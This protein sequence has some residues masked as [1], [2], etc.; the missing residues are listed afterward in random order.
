MLARLKDEEVNYHA[1][2][3]DSGKLELY[4]EDTLREVCG[5][6]SSSV[7]YID[8]KEGVDQ[9][10]DHGLVFPYEAK[11][12][13]FIVRYDKVK[14]YRQ[15][16][17]KIVKARFDSSKIL[18][19]FEKYIDFKKFSDDVGSSLNSMYLKNLNRQD[20]VALFD[21]V[22]I[23]R[24]LL[25][26]TYQSYRTEPEKV[27][28][29]REHLLNKGT[30]SSRA[31]ITKLIGISAGSAEQFVFQLLGTIPKNEKSQ[32]RMIKNRLQ[33]LEELAKVY[34]Y[35][36]LRAILQATTKDVLD[37]KTLYLTGVFYDKLGQ[38]P[39]GYD[40]KRL[41]R[42]KFRYSNII[43]ISYTRILDLYLLLYNSPR[44]STSLDSSRFLYTYYRNLGLKTWRY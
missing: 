17:L 20:V 43:Q 28:Q 22:S 36:K 18:F 11:Q 24:D 6:K 1:A 31:E 37:I 8:S 30:F 23:P 16:L 44:W 42:Y 35:G 14:R 39:E 19:L 27:M 40:S 29:V 3:V 26:F 32:V 41:S 4:L 33:V 12:W 34:G 10:K 25:L 5:A 7:F 38:V 15:T 9:L 21:D 13:L 2:I